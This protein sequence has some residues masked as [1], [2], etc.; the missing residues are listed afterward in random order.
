VQFAVPFAGTF[1]PKVSIRVDET[2]APRLAVVDGTLDRSTVPDALAA[3]EPYFRRREPLALDLRGVIRIDSAG[4]A[5]LAHAFRSLG[6]TERG[7]QLRYINPEVEKALKLTSWDVSAAGQRAVPRSLDFF[8]ATGATAIE[9]GRGVLRFL[10]VL[11]ESFYY[12]VIAPVKGQRP[13]WGSIVEQMA[14]LGAGSAP[15]V[16]LVALLVGLTTAFQSAYQIRRFGADIY[17]ADLVA[18]AMMVE[19]GPLMAGILVAGRNGAAITAE[20]GT[21]QVNEEIDALRIMGVNPIQYLAVPRLWAAVLTQPLLGVSAAVVG[22]LGGLAIAVTYLDVSL[23]SFLSRAIQALAFADLVR[24]LAKSVV[25]GALVV[26][27]GV[28]YGFGVAGGA[29]GVG[30]ATT[31]S[32]VASILLIIAADCVFSFI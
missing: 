23:E 18:I 25:F 31:R 8:E 15:I 26:S 13:R 6:A 1:M 28:F 12:G 3:L 2:A 22:I 27:A 32:V 29:A 7:C 5:L 19:L 24:N 9:A 4:V 16:L 11:S 30:R 21:M 17:V 10:H 20:L 14:R